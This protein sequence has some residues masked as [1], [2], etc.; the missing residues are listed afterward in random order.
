MR[1]QSAKSYAWGAAALRIYTGVFWIS[2]AIPKFTNGSAF[3]PPNGSMSAAIA[4]AAAVT[5]GP[6]HAFLV[7]TV[8]THIEVFAQLVRIGELA[9]GI[10][11]LLGLFTRLGGFIGVVLAAAFVLDQGQIG[12]GGW[13][14]LGATALTLSAIS[15]I[16]PTGRVMGFDALLKRSSSSYDDVPVM[17]VPPIRPEPAPQPT[18]NTVQTTVGEIPPAQA[19][20]MVPHEPGPNGANGGP[21]FAAPA[22][23][24]PQIDQGRQSV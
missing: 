13:S 19:P 10:L 23:A 18:A 15:L 2:L 8:Q 20:L 17:P 4:K 1:I 9:A 11:L 14:T 5:S 24:G 21:A 3:L 12:L 6:Y 7:G 22:S 16:L